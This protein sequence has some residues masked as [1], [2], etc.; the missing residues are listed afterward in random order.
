MLRKCQLIS[1]FFCLAAFAPQAMVPTETRAGWDEAKASYEKGDYLKAYEEFKV[2]A[3][4]GNADAQWNLGVMFA[5]GQGVQKDYVEA[6]KWTG[7]AAEQ[8]VADAQY[9]LG[10]MYY[11]GTGVPQDYTEAVK[12]FRRA[13]E[14][15]VAEAQYDLGVMYYN[16]TGMPED[17][18]QAHVCF[19]LAAA[20]GNEEAVAGR[21]S[22]A[23]RMT[24]SQ[25][26]EAQRI[27]EGWKPKSQR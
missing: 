4:Q 11:N 26:A 19:N 14:Q 10:V 21:D 15:G 16:G 6:V 20:Q 24:A 5:N 8:G 1:L 23:R 25:I 9:N 3:E 7:K 22:V 2:L 18:V 12:W 17:F 13:A 27:A